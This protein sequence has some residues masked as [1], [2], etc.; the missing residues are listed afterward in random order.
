MSVRLRLPGHMIFHHDL[1]LMVV[2]LKGVLNPERIQRDIAFV[3]AAESR[4]A[5]PF[6]RFVDMSA[7][8][9]IRLDVAQ[10]SKTAKLR[11]MD[12]LACPTVKSAY[13]VTTKRAAQLAEMCAALTKASSLQVEVFE[14]IRAAA[15]WL[16]V[17]EQDLAGPRSF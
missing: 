15:E 5:K 1:N 9:Q 12:Y 3:T 14:D 2:K 11:R 8:T 6:N 7:I 13:F 4:A 16:G 17:T 10:V